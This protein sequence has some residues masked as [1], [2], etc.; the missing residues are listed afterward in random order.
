M[1]LFF[2]HSA[3]L[4]H[5]FKS[6]I[7]VS[8]YQNHQPQVGPFADLPFPAI[9]LSRVSFYRAL[10]VITE[11]VLI[12]VVNPDISIGGHPETEDFEDHTLYSAF[13]PFRFLRSHRNEV[14][15]T[16]RSPSVSHVCF[17]SVAVAFATYTFLYVSRERLRLAL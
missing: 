8:S 16:A 13:F 3:S 12:E 11:R 9:H 2:Q 15:E 5:F 7:L 1:F 14:V 10:N 6:R 17:A 4:R